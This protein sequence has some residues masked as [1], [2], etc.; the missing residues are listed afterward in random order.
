MVFMDPGF[1]YITLVVSGGREEGR[2]NVGGINRSLWV[3]S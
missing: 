1:S 2:E 3:G